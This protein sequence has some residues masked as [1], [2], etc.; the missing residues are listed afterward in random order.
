MTV[1]QGWEGWDDYASFYDWENRRT[2]GRRDLAFWRRCVDRKR[3]PVLELGCGT[4]RLTVPLA[5]AG[6]SMTGLDRSA[7]MLEYAH[8]RAARLPRR[9]RPS[10]IR[11]D[12]RALPFRDSS[13][14]VVLAPYGLLQ[15]LLGNRDLDRGL[16]EALRVLRRDGLIGIDLVP[17]LPVWAEHGPRECLRGSRNGARI[18][19]IESVRQDRRRHLT[20]FDEVFIERRGRHEQQRKFSLT[21][22]TR[23]MSEIREH[24]ERAGFRVTS[25]FGDYRGGPWHER[26]EVW[27]ILARPSRG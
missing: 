2:F 12:I 5:R 15:S 13:F 25:A 26:A 17:E 1:Q 3:G 21:F 9:D 7:E 8:S 19:L 16:G 11:G 18:T 6:A 4:G 14:E 10:L 22:R 20:I 23:P 24:L 27:L